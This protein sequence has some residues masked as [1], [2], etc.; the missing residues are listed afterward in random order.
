MESRPRTDRVKPSYRRLDD[1]PSEDPVLDRPEPA[2][3][4]PVPAPSR[5]AERD[6]PKPPAAPLSPPGSSRDRREARVL[7]FLVSRGAFATSAPP[8]AV[9]PNGGR[10]EAAKR[11]P[12]RPRPDPR[13]P[14]NAEEP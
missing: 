13:E 5:E 8:E 6:P 10:S 2:P 7:A 1:E 3:T 4:E 14:D 12:A 9:T 11:P